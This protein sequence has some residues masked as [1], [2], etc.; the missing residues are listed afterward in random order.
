MYNAMY[1]EK[2]ENIFDHALALMSVSIH[3]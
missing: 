2:W 3:V 1:Y